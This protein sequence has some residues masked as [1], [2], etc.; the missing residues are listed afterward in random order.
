MEG[1]LG[2]YGEA[3][4]RIDRSCNGTALEESLGYTRDRMVGTGT[5]KAVGRAC[6]AG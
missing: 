6:N 1:S 2:A 4:A 3:A 5:I